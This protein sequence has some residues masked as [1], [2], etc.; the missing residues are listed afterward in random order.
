MFARFLNPVIRLHEW[1]YRRFTLGIPQRCFH[2]SDL[3]RGGYVSQCGQDK[4]IVEEV[5]AGKRGGTFV[6]VGAHDGCSFSNTYFLERYLN[7]SGI[8]VEPMPLAFE[9]LSKNRNCIKINGCVAGEKGRAR[10]WLIEGYSEMLSGLAEKY[11]YRHLNRIERELLQYGGRMEEIDVACFRF[12]D[13][14]FNNELRNIDYVS[15]DVEGAEYEI[16]S[17]IDFGSLDINV[18][19]VENNYKDYRIPKLMKANGYKMVAV[20]CDEFYVKNRKNQVL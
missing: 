4:F 12:N 15:I 11:D 1:K 2:R 9:K 7:W 3:D 6:D 20:I 16:L 13:L 19:S 8:A 5:F 17:G 18:F 14:V 10:F